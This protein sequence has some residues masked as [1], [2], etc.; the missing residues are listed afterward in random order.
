MNTLLQDIRYA[1]RGLIKTP[2]F[3]VG[4]VLTLALGIGINATMFGV[5]DTLFL[6]A[7]GGVADPHGIVRV[8]Y[9]HRSATFGDYTSSGGS[10]PTYV[11]LRDGVPGFEQV[12][13]YTTRTLGLGRGTAAIQVNAAVTSYQFFPML[14]LHPS[15]GRFFTD[16]EDRIG[17]DRVA[18]LTWPFWQRQFGGDPSVVGRALPLGKGTYTVIGVAPRDFTGI[19]LAATDL[20]LPIHPAAEGD[21]VSAEAIGSRNWQWMSTMARI[22]PGVLPATAAAEATVAY[23]RGVS[24]G[25]RKDSTTVAALGAIQESR[26]PGTS[27]DAKVALWIGIVASIVLL[28]VCANVANLLLARGVARRRELA[29]RA[30]L[31]AGRGGLIRALLTESLVL[32]CVGGAAAV[33]LAIW[34]GSAARSIL[35]PDLSPDVPLV[36]GRMLLFTAAAVLLTTVLTG[37]VPAIQAT[38]TDLVSAFK[39]GGHGSTGSGLA[40]RTT[41]LVAQIALTLVLLVGA[42]LFVRSLRKVQGISLGFDADRVLRVTMDLSGAGISEDAA[43]Q[44]Y[45][46]LLDRFRLIPGVER[47][48]ASMGTPFDYSFAESMRAEGVD[49]IPNVKSGGPYYQAVTPDYLAT[50]GTRV[51]QGRDFN[52]SDIVGAPPVAI[53][54]ASLARLVWRSQDAIGKCLYLGQDTTTTCTRVVG[55][56][57]DAKRGG[58]TETESLLYYV[59]FAQHRNPV[60]S[61]VY[62]R[63]RPGARGVAGALLR[64]TQ[65]AGNLPFA[66]IES[67]A[68][69]IAPQLRSW[70]LG[71]QAFTAFGL[72][73]LL[74]AA[75]GIFA[76]LS[77][78]VSQRTKEIGVRVA[79]GAQSAHVVRM[80]V[81]QGIRAAL[82][83]T[84]LGAIGA[85]ALG[86]AIASLL[87][88]VPATD[89]LVFGSVAV[90]L[91]SVSLVAAYLPARRASRI[92]PMI[93]LRSE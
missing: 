29:V 49:S 6:R 43:N 84:V 51:Q 19:D 3:T 74:I 30:S 92:A 53:V 77:Y 75:T 38:R 36:D 88:Q 57:A 70:R 71:A 72:L 1:A 41:L 48:A 87:Y 76:V 27:S 40:T 9:Q 25:K 55:I 8:Y 86:R 14:G 60:I 33:V 61:G 82:I 58:V 47:G 68:D 34:G 50:M 35:L 24:E 39:S 79:L 10:F 23:R 80:I 20:I 5:V 64:E 45:L 4:V 59:P 85:L 18:V 12:S 89:P 66:K 44:I 78:G 52:A 21:V 26:G 90:V 73:A 11:D 15:L 83:G 69:Q 32:A 65:G 2:A 16:A 37:M 17:G 22:K 13:A 42:G 81:G 54:G 93:A 56:A 67:I 63:M 62:V 91:L 46:R 7:P 28:I 31:G